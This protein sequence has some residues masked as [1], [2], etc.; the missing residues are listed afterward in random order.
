MG[1]LI[2]DN[3]YH[4]Y[5]RGNNKQ[6]IFIDNNDYI[7]FL[8]KIRKEIL[9]EVDILA[10]CL[11]PN[12][13]HLMIYTSLE[14]NLDDF[15]FKFGNMLSSFTQTMN[16]KYHKT[17]SLFQQKTKFK[18]IDK[19]NYPIIC[20]NYIHQN[21]FHSKLVRKLEDYSYS[22][23]KD[24]LGLRNGTLCNKKL[25]YELLDLPECNEKLL[26]STYD[27]IPDEKIKKIF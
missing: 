12:H 24:Y 9:F 3:F 20:F 11:M 2:K 1:K 26:K 27:S 22:S 5:N 14:E 19:E 4:V 13:F 10:W 23:L 8:K 7:F 6:L 15:N 16:L 25:A 21:P 18:L 17:G